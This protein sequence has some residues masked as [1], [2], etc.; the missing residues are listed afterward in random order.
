MK[1]KFEALNITT[2]YV[3]ETSKVRQICIDNNYYTRGDNVAYMNMFPMAND[4][5]YSRNY[6][7]VIRGIFDVA[8]DIAAH[9]E[10]DSYYNIVQH[11]EIIAD[12]IINEAM[13][14]MSGLAEA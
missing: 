7:E 10:L 4:L 5:N 2:E 14:T 8:M 12:K 9:S 6:E 1:I 11:I 3:V 13:Y